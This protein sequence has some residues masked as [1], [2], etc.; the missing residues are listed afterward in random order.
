[1]RESIYSSFFSFSFLN[2]SFSFFFLNLTTT[3][4]RFVQED[5]IA[6]ILTRYYDVE[7]ILLPHRKLGEGIPG[8]L[9]E[10]YNDLIDEIIKEQK[11]GGMNDIEEDEEDE[12]EEE[13]NEEEGTRLYVYV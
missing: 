9:I 2:I 3:F 7:E 4:S 10:F 8:I 5:R 12:E 6:K 13:E 11:S 1:M